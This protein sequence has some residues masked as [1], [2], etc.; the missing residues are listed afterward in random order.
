MQLHEALRDAP[1]FL[2]NAQDTAQRNPVNPDTLYMWDNQV[3]AIEHFLAATEDVAKGNDDLVRMRKDLFQF[4]RAI[5][6]KVLE[7]ELKQE[8]QEL[9]P[10]PTEAEMVEDLTAYGKE[11]QGLCK[12]LEKV[13]IK[14]VKQLEELEEPR[15]Q[16]NNFLVDSEAYLGKNP[17]LDGHRDAV[18]K[19]RDQLEEKIN[20]VLRE[21]RQ[22]DLAGGDEE[23]AE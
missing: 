9:P 14:T 3:T 13:Q 19:A 20:T 18:R 5:E 12:E 7:F 15:Q 11:L 16:L 21:W 2:R 6:A 1:A 17:D 4:K 22:Q 23:E 10:E 8:N